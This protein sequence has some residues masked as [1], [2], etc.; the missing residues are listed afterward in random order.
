MTLSTLEK[1]DTVVRDISKKQSC[2]PLLNALESSITNQI[3][4]KNAKK[5]AGFATILVQ[6]TAELYP[7]DLAKT[8]MTPVVSKLLQLSG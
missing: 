1:L 2:Q 6:I 8:A 3:K 4:P 5:L 7:A